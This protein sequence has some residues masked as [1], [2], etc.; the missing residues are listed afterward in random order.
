MNAAVHEQH[1]THGVAGRRTAGYI[2]VVLKSVLPAYLS[3]RLHEWV[4]RV[5][6]K[7]HAV[8]SLPLGAK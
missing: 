4:E 6:R 5:Q 7:K 1:W 8:W 2:S 3:L